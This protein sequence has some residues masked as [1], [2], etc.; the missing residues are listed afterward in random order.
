MIKYPKYFSQ[1]T[2]KKSWKTFG[3]QYSLMS[4]KKKI[5]KKLLKF[6]LYNINEIELQLQLNFEEKKLKSGFGQNL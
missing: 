1:N 3:Y 4:R 2:R 5:G 6:K